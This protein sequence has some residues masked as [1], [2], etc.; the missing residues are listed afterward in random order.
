MRKN[1][2]NFRTAVARTT[3]IALFAVT[4]ASMMAQARAPFVERPGIIEY[5]GEMIVRP[6]TVDAWKKKGLSPQISANR[7]QNAVRRIQGFVVSA[8]NRT[9]EYIVRVPIGYNENSFSQSLM[10]SGDYEYAVPNWMCYPTINPN[11]TLFGQ[12]WH[13]PKIQAPQAWD[14]L[15]GDNTIICAIVDTGIDTDHPDLAPNRVLG[16]NSVTNTTEAAGGIVEDDNGHGTH[17]AGDAAAIGN[18]GIGVSGVGWNFKI[19][20]I[21]ATSGGGG[22]SMASL[23]GGA[24]W[25][26]DNGAKVVSVSFTGVDSPA[27]Q[28]TGAYCK[29]NGGLMCWA[30]GN[31]NRNLT[32]NHP[33]V[34]VVGASDNNDGKASF[35]AFGPGVHVFAPGVNIMSTTMGGGYGNSSGTSMAT[36]VTN[37][38]IAMIWAADP[39]LSP[40]EVQDILES[41][42]DNIGP[43]N[44]FG[45]GRINVFKAVDGAGSVPEIT[46]GPQSI[47]TFEGTYISG[48][49]NSVKFDDT[50]YYKTK[51]T[52]VAGLGFTASAEYIYQINIPKNKLRTINFSMLMRQQSAPSVTGLTFLWNYQLNKYDFVGANPIKTT[53]GSPIVRAIGD[54]NKYVG[55]TG[56]V[57]IVIRTLAP[58]SKARGFSFFFDLDHVEMKIKAAP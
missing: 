1:C 16:Y 7:I 49:L 18:N 50:D 29:A 12:Q 2:I 9:G 55:P 23:T 57:K 37:G 45:H 41:T 11:D 25:A 44:I 53:F 56:E 13:H 10:F 31:D 22:A 48:D 42:C 32:F 40:Q 3:M 34:I 47:S 54:F 58:F 39:T 35:S 24:Q 20:G 27:V 26:I 33:D 21:K 5:T 19:M 28:T 51:S 14:I 4:A 46:L 17:C 8:N 36:P 52:I 15:T 30:A 6:Y 43:S 38:A